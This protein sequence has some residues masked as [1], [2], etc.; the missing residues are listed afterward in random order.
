MPF[1]SIETTDFDG[2]E[3]AEDVNQ[4]KPIVFFDVEVYPNLFYISWKYEGANS[5][6]VHMFNPSPQE[7]EELLQM[8]LVGFHNRGYDNHILYARYMGFDNAAIYALSQ[9]IINSKDFKTRFVEAYNLSYADVYDFISKK[10]S[11][12]KYELELGIRHME[13]DIPWDEPVPEEK[14][15]LVAEYCDN[16]VLATEAVW[17]ARKQDFAARQNSI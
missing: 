1:Y 13:M 4:E 7:V 3:K 17:N 9:D 11:L 5:T 2:K 10:Q 14:W 6:L 15:S 16:D 12:K 8:R